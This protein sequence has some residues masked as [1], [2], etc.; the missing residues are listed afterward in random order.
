MQLATGRERSCAFSD[1]KLASISQVH[2]PTV[3]PTLLLYCSSVS[4]ALRNHLVQQVCTGR[5]S[6]DRTLLP[7]VVADATYLPTHP[8]TPPLRLTPGV[9]SLE[10][11]NNWHHMSLGLLCCLQEALHC[12]RC[13]NTI[14]TPPFLTTACCMSGRQVQQVSGAAMHINNSKLLHQVLC[15]LKVSVQMPVVSKQHQ[16]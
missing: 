15:L 7:V 14:L 9:C 5:R 3:T 11:G 13:L 8:L 12:C 4:Q 2:T 16:H 1:A 6:P 10:T